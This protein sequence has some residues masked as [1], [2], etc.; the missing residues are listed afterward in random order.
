MRVF[1]KVDFS[2][3]EILL[4]L[5]MGN[6]RRGGLAQLYVHEYNTRAA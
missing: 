3:H 2:A 6:S 4:D 1:G 5:Y